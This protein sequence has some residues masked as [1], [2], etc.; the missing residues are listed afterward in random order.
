[1]EDSLNLESP[2]LKV[3]YEQWR[4]SIRN[5]QRLVEKEI[6]YLSAPNADKEAAIDRLMNLK[7]K[8]SIKLMSDGSMA[9]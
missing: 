4:K 7:S 8:V 2:F 5:Q 6:S 1:M 9:I 3:P